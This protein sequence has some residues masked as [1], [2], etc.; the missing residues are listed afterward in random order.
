MMHFMNSALAKVVY[1]VV[2]LGTSLSYRLYSKIQLA[3]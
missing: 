3:S 2:P 1:F